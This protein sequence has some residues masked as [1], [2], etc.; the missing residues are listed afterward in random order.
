MKRFKMNRRDFTV[1]TS[2]IRSPVVEE[3]KAR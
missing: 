2:S 3:L 1:E